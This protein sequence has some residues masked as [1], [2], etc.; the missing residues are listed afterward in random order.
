MENDTSSEAARARLVALRSISGVARL[1]QALELSD[2]VRAISD[3]G[4][5]ARELEPRA[6]ASAAD[7][8]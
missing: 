3:A 2:A 5:R 8:E 6:H 7:A 4:R 1:E